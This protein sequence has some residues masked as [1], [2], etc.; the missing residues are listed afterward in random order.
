MAR[1]Q[2]PVFHV[3]DIAWDTDGDDPAEL[4]LPSV[5]VMQGDPEDFANILSDHYGWCITG[6]RVEQIAD[7]DL[8]RL[9]ELRFFSAGGE[10]SLT[11]TD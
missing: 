4:N 7:G 5:V 11:D 6:L 10:S 9:S 1:S 3:S 2:L 8:K